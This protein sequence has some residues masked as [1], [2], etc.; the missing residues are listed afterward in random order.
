MQHYS[1]A[2]QTSPGAAQCYASG[3]PG[4]L[5]AGAWSGLRHAPPAAA[6]RSTNKRSCKA[7]PSRVHLRPCNLTPVALVAG[8]HA[9]GLVSRHAEQAASAHAPG[10][11]HDRAVVPAQGMPG[12]PGALL[13]HTP[14]FRRQLLTRDGVC[15]AQRQAAHADAACDHSELSCMARHG[16][17]HS[18][19]SGHARRPAL[20]PAP[21]QASAGA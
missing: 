9:H 1:L 3:R 10:Q 19:R 18:A 16:G 5:C 4:E 20:P 12:A 13:C 11:V 7:W 21:V 8:M 14:R 15:F 6:R 17:R 2:L